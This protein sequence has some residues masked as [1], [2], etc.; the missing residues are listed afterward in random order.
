M[1]GKGVGVR[2]VAVGR[3][4]RS[5]LENVGSAEFD[6]MEVGVRVGSAVVDKGAGKRGLG[7]SGGERRLNGG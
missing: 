5:W 4:V 2:G 7:D 1:L 3:G 6:S